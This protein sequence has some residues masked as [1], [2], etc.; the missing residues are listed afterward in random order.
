MGRGSVEPLAGAAVID[1][2]APCDRG[3]SERVSWVVRLA[4]RVSVTAPDRVVDARLLFGCQGRLVLAM[5]VLKRHRPVPQAELADLLWPDGRIR[6]WEP[7]VGC[8]VSKVRA[9]LIAC[10]LADTVSHGGD[11]T[12]Q[13]QLPDGVELDI[14]SADSAVAAARRGAR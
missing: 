5:L 7:A 10:G 4:G 3:S 11:G 12:Y 13:L 8:V 14:E 2:P 9:F 1:I 6:T